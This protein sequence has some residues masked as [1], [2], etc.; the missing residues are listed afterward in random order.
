ML[1]LLYDDY[2]DHYV[3]LVSVITDFCPSTPCLNGATCL[4]A[5]GLNNSYNYTCSC[6]AGY[7][8]YQCQTGI[9]TNILN[10]L[11]HKFYEK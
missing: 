1:L 4:N 6:A 7:T 11:D 9:H 10:Q 2:S 5:V 8:G 3:N